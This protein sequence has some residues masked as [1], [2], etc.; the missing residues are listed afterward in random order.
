MSRSLRRE[1]TL[2]SG[3]VTSPRTT[4]ITRP[5]TQSPPSSRTGP[6]PTVVRAPAPSA[7]PWTCRPETE[8]SRR[9]PRGTSVRHDTLSATRDPGTVAALAVT[10][11][12]AV[13]SATWARGA[14]REPHS[15]AHAADTVPYASA[16]RVTTGP[17][18]RT[19]PASRKWVVVAPCTSAPACTRPS[20]LDHAVVEVASLETEA[21]PETVVVPSQTSVVEDA[22]PHPR[23]PSH[24]TGNDALT[25]PAT[26]TSPG[27]TRSAHA[28][29]PHVRFPLRGPEAC[30]SPATPA[31]PGPAVTVWARTSPRSSATP[32]AERSPH[33]RWGVMTA[34]PSP[35]PES[36]S[37]PARTSPFAN[38]SSASALPHARRYVATESLHTR[39]SRVTSV[40]PALASITDTSLSDSVPNTVTPFAAARSPAVSAPTTVRHSRFS[41][42]EPETTTT[43]AVV[44]S[45]LVTLTR[46]AACPALPVRTAREPARPSAAENCAAARESTPI[47]PGTSRRPSTCAAPARSMPCTS[48][49][50]VTSRRAADSSSSTRAS[51]ETRASRT[52]ASGP[53][54]AR[55]TLV[56]SAIPA[57]A[58]ASTPPA[59]S[60][61]EAV[62][63]AARR[64][65]P[66]RASSTAHVPLTLHAV[67]IAD[68]SATTRAARTDDANAASPP[69]PSAASISTSHA[70]STGPS[71]SR[72]P[73]RTS[74][75]VDSSG[76]TMG[77]PCTAFA[78]TSCARAP[79]PAVT[80]AR[81]TAGQPAHRPVSASTV[82]VAACPYRAAAGAAATARGPPT[83][84][85]RR[86]VRSG[87]DSTSHVS[88]PASAG[89]ETRTSPPSRLPARTSSPPSAHAPSMEPSNASWPSSSSRARSASPRTRRVP[90]RRSPPSRT[91]A[92]PARSRGTDHE[93]RATVSEPAAAAPR[94]STSPAADSA[95]PAAASPPTSTVGAVTA[96]A[97]A[98][99]WASSV[100]K[101]TSSPMSTGPR[102]RTSPA[103]VAG[104]RNTA[105]PRAMDASKNVNRPSGRSAPCG[106]KTTPS[107]T[108]SA[109]EL[110][111]RSK[112]R[113]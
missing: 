67:A 75:P 72:V 1:R 22:V 76:V 79:A 69:T 34:P 53:S 29:R 110:T 16:S 47:V 50:S 78:H 95:P 101:V 64:R 2:T 81:N 48:S 83:T 112:T 27:H 86:D 100:V 66:T 91:S 77:P 25:A 88:D 58:A 26:T 56:S 42:V 18:A 40:A 104:P 87:A 15:S 63:D 49:R 94:T 106:L 57:S 44:S 10:S 113:T 41:S 80:S 4:R 14:E 102:K 59:T 31:P 108:G 98:R 103:K 84:A 55:P 36:T 30:T 38:S 35:R 32:D 89:P 92:L 20:T 6:W 19:T 93:P 24:V 45:A 54:N 73:T 33:I 23:S 52:T 111:R 60:L 90:H 7:G 43:L 97:E 12:W 5:L 21:L 39:S 74:G 71:A 13:R 51:P 65:T 11:L 68:A 28:S 61:S 96:P 70:N 8:A 9:I 107:C 85:H 17:V 82:R 109:T 62:A 3:A 37:C 46:P 99:A 105:P